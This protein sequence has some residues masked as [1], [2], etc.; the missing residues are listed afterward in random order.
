MCQ[1]REFL[2]IDLQ[3]INQ[4]SVEI[5]IRQGKGYQPRF[6]YLSK[7]SRKMLRKY[8]NHRKDDFPALWVTHPRF[9]SQRMTY[10]GL[11]AV[12]TRRSKEAGN[13]VT[14]SIGDRDGFNSIKI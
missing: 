4:A 9:G 8:L 7:K 10:D 11:R 3:D 13:N 14:I 6:V 2:D 5:I 1:S 12:I